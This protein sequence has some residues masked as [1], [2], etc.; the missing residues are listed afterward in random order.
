M[1]RRPL[2]LC[3]ELI[4]LA[5]F[6]NAPALAEP[7]E[8]ESE[9]VFIKRM[10]KEMAAELEEPV[11]CTDRPTKIIREKRRG[12]VEEIIDF[13][14]REPWQESL[15]DN[16]MAISVLV[17]SIEAGGG[18]LSMEEALRL[19]N[20]AA[21]KN[22]SLAL[23]EL[24]RLYDS[25]IGVEKNKTTA[26]LLRLKA[27]ENGHVE[28]QVELGFYYLN[29]ESPQNDPKQAYK[30]FCRAA[31]NHNKWGQLS[32][33]RSDLYGQFSPKNVSS[34]IF[35]L[36]R[37]SENGSS[38]AQLELGYMYFGGEE[39]PKDL[40]LAVK[41]V[42]KAATAGNAEAQNMFALMIAEGLGTVSNEKL[43][44]FW[45]QKAADQG[46]ADAQFNLGTQY[47]DGKGVEKN[48][49][50]AFKWYK[51][52]A[53]QGHPLAQANLGKAY[54][55]GEGIPQNFL[56]G[57]RWTKAAAAQGV[58]SA[59]HNLALDIY[60]GRTLERNAILAHAFFSLAAT[61]GDASS[62]EKRDFI[63]KKLSKN[64][65]LESQSIATACYSS[66]FKDCP[67]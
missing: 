8:V 57:I 42:E 53:E 54:L 41:W 15:F 25:G 34:G 48:D 6:C 43:A 45:L 31:I 7:N 19:L 47:S 64:E 38:E 22:D 37:A 46:L 26:D 62:A 39:V 2:T 3:I 35:W 32:V 49:L 27:A 18:L 23:A 11:N 44:T 10:A 20:D 5:S 52:A 12:K 50:E 1:I 56:E 29:P 13:T 51:K 9:E 65:L 4:L 16:S 30:W 24:S 17:A 14:D 61:Q 28:S 40:S 58:A 66:N 33:G 36:E 63:A 60:E 67:I 55:D 59:L 21:N